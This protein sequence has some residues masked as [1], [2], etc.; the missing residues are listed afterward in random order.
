MCSATNWIKLQQYVMTFDDIG[1]QL[2][3]IWSRALNLIKVI[4]VK[5]LQLNIDNLP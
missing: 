3:L 1:A 2:R 4:I 5:H